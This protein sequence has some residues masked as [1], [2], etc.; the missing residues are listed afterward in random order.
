M[1]VPHTPSVDMWVPGRA[2]EVSKK[3]DQKVCD[4]CDAEAADSAYHLPGGFPRP[5]SPAFASRMPAKC[6]N[7]DSWVLI[8]HVV[9]HTHPAVRGRTPSFVLA[10]VWPCFLG[11]SPLGRSPLIFGPVNT[12]R[13]KL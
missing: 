5:S 7:T 11:R 9:K 12:E 2:G 10:K 6:C 8:Q 13:T 4:Q 1:D 3:E